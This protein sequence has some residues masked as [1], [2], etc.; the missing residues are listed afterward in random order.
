MHCHSAFLIFFL[1]TSFEMTDF[2]DARK[3]TKVRQCTAITVLLTGYDQ[4]KNKV[5][6]TF[7]W[8]FSTI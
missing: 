3:L 7:L 8:M 1:K 6:I 4:G 2:T 5:C